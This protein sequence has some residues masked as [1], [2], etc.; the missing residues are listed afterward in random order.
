MIKQ[1]P[2]RSPKL[3]NSAKGQS[4]TLRLFCCNGG[5]ESAVLAHYPD[6]SGTGKMGGKSSD[7][8]AGDSCFEC[9]TVI[10]NRAE[11]L[12]H[13]TMEDYWYFVHRSMVETLANRF[14][15]G[16]IKVT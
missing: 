10:D 13:Y 11:F 8:S 14:E 5:G 4:C 15:R 3:R 6:G 12:K 16:L 7:V 1:K 9:H 2:Q